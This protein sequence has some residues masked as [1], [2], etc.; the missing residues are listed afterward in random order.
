[1]KQ[2]NRVF[3]LEEELAK[4]A[5]HDF[6]SFFDQYGMYVVIFAIFGASSSFLFVY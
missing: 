2:V 4:E 3:E 5:D 6:I 1:M